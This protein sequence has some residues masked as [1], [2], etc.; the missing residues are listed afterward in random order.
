MMA[1]CQKALDQFAIKQLEEV[2][3]SSRKGE[4]RPEVTEAMIDANIQQLREALTAEE[5]KK[6]ELARKHEQELRREQKVNEIRQVIGTKGKEQ[7]DLTQTLYHIMT[8]LTFLEEKIDRQQSQLDEIVVGLQTVT[9]IVKGKHPVEKKQGEV[10]EDKKQVKKLMSDAMKSADPQDQKTSN[11][12]GSSPPSSP[13]NTPSSPP[14]SP[15]PQPPASLQG[16]VSTEPVKLKMKEEVKMKLPFTFCNKRDEN[17]LLWIA[18]I[19]TY[20]S[21]TPVESES[22]VAFSTSCLGGEAKEWVLVEA[23]AAGFDDIGTWTRTLTLKQF[24]GKINEHFLDK[25]TT[26]KAFDQLTTIGQRH[27]TSM[28]ALSRE[29]DRLLQVPGLNLQDNQ[30]LYIYSRA[31]PAPI[32]GQLVA[33]SK[34][35]KYNYRQ[36]RDLALQREQMTSQVKN[37]YA[38]VVK[39]GG[40]GGAGVGKRVLW[41]QK[42]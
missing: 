32:H 17:L 20:Y 1:Q 12:G 13:P 7:T 38:S 21:T 33:E 41:R 35:G 29:V 14:S 23:N 10:Q 31:L 15:P 28:E 34:F 11:G 16:K 8:Y 18:E 37:S 24:L 39:Y 25:T 6:E 4:I 5:R 27:W 19:Q 42:R 30:V 22:Q 9:N 36:F 40:G 3:E 26:D 2:M